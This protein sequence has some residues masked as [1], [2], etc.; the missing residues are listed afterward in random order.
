[1]LPTKTLES[2]AGWQN[3]FTEASF[4][5]SHFGISSS[6]G[7]SSPVSSGPGSSVSV[8]VG[9]GVSVEEL[10]EVMEDSAALTAVDCAESLLE[11][12]DVTAVVDASSC[13]YVMLDG[14]V[15]RHHGLV[16]GV[17]PVPSGALL[18]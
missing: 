14:T 17:F 3:G 6:F 13:R 10:E 4:F 18:K 12:G 2:L 9:L 7:G 11:D 1:M 16:K 15:D 8:G 5:T